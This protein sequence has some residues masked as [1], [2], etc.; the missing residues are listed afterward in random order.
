MKKGNFCSS[1]PHG[2]GQR[3]QPPLLPPSI[4]IS[5]QFIC[6]IPSSPLL[7]RPWSIK[8]C[9]IKEW[10]RVRQIWILYLIIE[11]ICDLYVCWDKIVVIYGWESLRNTVSDE[12]FII[13]TLHYV[14]SHGMPNISCYHKSSL[15]KV[16]FK[17]LR[18]SLL[19]CPV[20]VVIEYSYNEQLLFMRKW[21]RHWWTLESRGCAI[22]FLM[23]SWLIWQWS[24]GLFWWGADSPDNVVKVW[25]SW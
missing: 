12:L 11:R 5:G 20:M 24:P 8:L 3:G 4:A 17:V 7:P 16:V 15:V 23:G 18:S 22:T 14:C 6:R 25:L 13:L 9:W 21:W 1:C 2:A 10:D 19:F